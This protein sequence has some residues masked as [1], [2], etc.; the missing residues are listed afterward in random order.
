M[1]EEIYQCKKMFGDD[2]WRTKQGIARESDKRPGLIFT[3]PYVK[4][5]IF[6]DPHTEWLWKYGAL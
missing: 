1:I 4:K 5:D 6:I 2:V 3:E